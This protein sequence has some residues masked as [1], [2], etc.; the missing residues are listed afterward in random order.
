MFV[1]PPSASAKDKKPRVTARWG[2]L[3]QGVATLTS[4]LNTG[5]T[6]SLAELIQ[7]DTDNKGHVLSGNIF[8]IFGGEAC[9]FP[10]IGGSYDFDSSGVGKA[11]FNLTIPALDP[12]GDFPCVNFFLALDPSDTSVTEN[13][14]VV[15]ANGKKQISFSSADDFLTDA[16]PVALGADKG[17][18]LALTGQCLK[19]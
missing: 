13:Y 2:C 6:I 11:S 4:G 12:D 9:T 7:F 19:Q 15:L 5:L 3:G 17:D 14:N 8:N 10:I 1:A 16:A 18:L